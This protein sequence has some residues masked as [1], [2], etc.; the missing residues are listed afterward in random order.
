MRGNERIPGL[1][2]PVAYQEFPI[3][4]RGNEAAIIRRPSAVVAFQFPIP[5]RG[6]EG[7]A[8]TG[9][10]FAAAPR[11]PIPMRGNEEFLTLKIGDTAE[12]GF[13]SP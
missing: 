5:M 6:N 10:S 3:P 2:V 1:S 9:S 8:P 13:R 11:F 7:G 4:M 12:A